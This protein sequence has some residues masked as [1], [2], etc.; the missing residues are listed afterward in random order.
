MDIPSPK[1]PFGVLA[2]T[3]EDNDEDVEVSGA[4][5]FIQISLCNSLPSLDS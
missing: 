3:F 5:S 4:S 1:E 2:T